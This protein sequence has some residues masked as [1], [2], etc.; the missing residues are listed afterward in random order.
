[1]V[2]AA[3]FAFCLIGCSLTSFYIGRQE[4]IEGTVQYFIDA[5]I[6]EVEDEDE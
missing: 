5:G 6:L 4:G 2:E 1:M 3:I